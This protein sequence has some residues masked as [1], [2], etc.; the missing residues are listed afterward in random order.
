MNLYPRG[1]SYFDEVEVELAGELLDR[2]FSVEATADAVYEF[3]DL[4]DT[5]NASRYR[6][7]ALFHV[8]A[9]Q[10]DR[11][12]WH[13][14]RNPV[15]MQLAFEGNKAA[16]DELNHYE[17]RDVVLRLQYLMDNDLRHPSFPEYP[18]IDTSGHG[19][20]LTLWCQSVGLEDPQHITLPFGRRS[21]KANAKA[22]ADAR[23]NA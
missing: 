7:K 10:A 6:K 5:R 3:W 11:W 14:S 9:I 13:A 22:K 17:R 12:N 16:W 8:K 2:G 4:G 1:Q 21:R 18:I 19:S 15:T 23:V 20:G